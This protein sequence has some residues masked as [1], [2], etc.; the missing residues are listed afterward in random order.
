MSQ[1]Y[2]LFIKQAMLLSLDMFG[3][4]SEDVPK[5]NRLFGCEIRRNIPSIYT[6]NF[7]Q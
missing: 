7:N 6:N 2:S 1:M 5:Y 3:S 4:I